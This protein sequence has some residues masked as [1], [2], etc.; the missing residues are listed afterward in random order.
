MVAVRLRWLPLPAPV[1]NVVSVCGHELKF[2]AAESQSYGRNIGTT[3]H[4][5]P[6]QDYCNIIADE[7][8][9]PAA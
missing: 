9:P 5:L 8:C 6:L 1:L 3:P 4:S 2:M 7:E